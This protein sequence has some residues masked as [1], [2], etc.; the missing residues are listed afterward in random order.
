MKKVL[1]CLL[2][3]GFTTS[4]VWASPAPDQKHIA[5]MKKKIAGCVDHQRRI[6]IETYDDR[7]LL[8][9]VTEAGEDDFVLSYAGRTT[10]LSYA[11]VKRVKWPSAVVKQVKVVAATAAV[12][13][14]LVVFFVLIGGLK[15]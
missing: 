3:I 13:G 11:D 14:G 9:V 5:S 6:V 1:I 8:G 15:G 12:V 7:R 4:Q 2:V 10:S